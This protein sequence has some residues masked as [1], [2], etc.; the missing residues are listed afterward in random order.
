MNNTIRQNPICILCYLLCVI[1]ITMFSIN[2]IIIGISYLSGILLYLS[3][4]GGVKT[5]IRLGYSLLFVL[6]STLLNPIFSRQG[7]TFLF[8]I[9]GLS[10]TLEAC[11]YG[12]AIGF[13]FSGVLVWFG[14]VNILLDSDKI[15]YI[16][17]KY[18][19]KIGTILSV[20][21][22][23]FPKY[24]AQY[25]KIDNNFKG[26]G[27]FEQTNFISKVRLKIHALS[28]LITWSIEGALTLSD[29][30]SARGY[31]LKKKRV[32]GKYK[33]GV[34]ECIML[35]CYLAIGIGLLVAIGLGVADFYFYP[36]FKKLTFD[37]N[38]YFYIVT[39]IFM[40]TLLII[41]VWGLAKWQFTISKI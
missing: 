24:V 29:S 14:V 30:M 12:M 1:F 21:L 33:F 7:M 36:T 11:A 22:G 39:F 19:P 9:F 41:R 10:V 37:S 16:F 34:K 40:N 4:A 17:G 38:I 31:D 26:L 13:M 5:L 2:P 32:F 18:T 28:T 20:S 8:E 23:L 15:S 6:I 35:V 27:L 25:K 3:L